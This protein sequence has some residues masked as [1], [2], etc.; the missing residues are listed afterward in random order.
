MKIPAVGES[1]TEVTVAKWLK[2]DGAQ[3]SR[4]EVIAEIKYSIEK[5]YGRKGEEVVAMNLKAVDNTL[6]NLFEVQIPDTITSQTTMI[7]PV[8]ATAPE[9]VQ[10]A[11]IEAAGETTPDSGRYCGVSEDTGQSACGEVIDDVGVLLVSVSEQSETAVARTLDQFKE[12]IG[13]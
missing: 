3:V 12:A 5:T 13:Q 4:D 11:G 9:F 1:I 10:N 2:P 7:P 6:A 8:P